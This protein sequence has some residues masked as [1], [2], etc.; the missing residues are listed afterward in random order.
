MGAHLWV[1]LGSWHAPLMDVTRPA[2]VVSEGLYISEDTPIAVH[3]GGLHLKGLAEI[4]TQKHTKAW[5]L[6]ATE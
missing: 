6:R 2:V 1:C 3:T 4:I 5:N